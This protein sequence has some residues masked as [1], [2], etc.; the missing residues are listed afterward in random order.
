MVTLRAWWPHR[1]VWDGT[2]RDSV[3]AFVTPA[4]GS[5]ANSPDDSL[6]VAIRLQILPEIILHSFR[7]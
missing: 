4:T 5:Y 1:K 3:A 6:C 2:V 7:V